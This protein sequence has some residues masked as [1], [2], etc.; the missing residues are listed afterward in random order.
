MA[1]KPTMSGAKDA[2]TEKILQEM[3]AESAGNGDAPAPGTG[4]G[5]DEGADGGGQK[6]PAPSKPAEVPPAPPAPPAGDEGDGGEG[7]EGKDDDDEGGLKPPEGRVPLMMPLAKHQRQKANWEKREAELLAEIE[8]GKRGASFEGVKPQIRKLA[9]EEGLDPD[10]VEKLVKVVSS[11]LTVPQDVSKTLD[12]MRAEQAQRDVDAKFETEFSK[13]AAKFPD[14]AKLREKLYFLA[15][16]ETPVEVDGTAY[17]SNHLPLKVLYEFL[18]EGT[19][20]PKRTAEPARSGASNRQGQVQWDENT[21]ISK[22]SDEEF[23]KYSEYMAKKQG[24]TL[25]RIKH[26]Y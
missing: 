16:S 21:D 15:F 24:G 8:A 18:T 3:A 5:A 9:E 7:G 25:L 12:A 26:R 1:K 22:L 23:A 17:P 19:P 4:E 11:T 6:P 14:A 10:L 2:D 13:F 20:T